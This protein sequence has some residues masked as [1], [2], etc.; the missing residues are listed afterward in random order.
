MGLFGR[1]K[2]H[3]KGNFEEKKDYVI[4]NRQIARKKVYGL[5]YCSTLQVK[6]FTMLPYF[7][8]VLSFSTMTF[9]IQIAC[10]E[11]LIGL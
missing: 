3:T 1:S 10:F 2:R 8:H 7:C 5:M 6:I 9:L 11:I 4:T